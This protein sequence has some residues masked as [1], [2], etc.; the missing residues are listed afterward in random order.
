MCPN[1]TECRIFASNCIAADDD[2]FYNEEADDIEIGDYEHQSE[3]GE[4]DGD[5]QLDELLMPD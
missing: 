2:S 3:A 4:A 1:L 5:D